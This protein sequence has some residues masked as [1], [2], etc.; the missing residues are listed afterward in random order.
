MYCIP[1]PRAPMKSISAAP[2]RACPIRWNISLTLTRIIF[3]PLGVAAVL[4]H[5]LPALGRTRFL[6]LF[7]SVVVG[8]P[9]FAFGGAGGQAEHQDQGERGFHEYTRQPATRATAISEVGRNTFQ[10]RRIS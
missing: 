9:A 1:R 6:R 5:Q 2:F 3:E 10:P 7:K 4:Q 8:D